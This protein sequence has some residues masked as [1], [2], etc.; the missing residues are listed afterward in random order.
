MRA[1]ERS[2]ERRS[3]K[4]GLFGMLGSVLPRIGSGARSLVLSGFHGRVALG[5]TLA[6][7]ASLALGSSSAVAS[8]LPHAFLSWFGSAGTGAG[9]FELSGE[10]GVAVDQ[11]TGDVYV[12]DTGNHRVDEFTASGVFIHAFGWGVL[13]GAAAPQTCTTTTTC[14]AGLPGPEPGQ[15]EAPTFLAVDNTP[16][17]AG[18]LYVA[19]SG[20]HANERQTVTVN[21]TGGSYTLS[22]TAP[23][24]DARTTAGSAV[25]TGALGPVGRPGDPVS[26]PGIP[27]GATFAQRL[28]E[29]SF[30]LSA[31]ATATAAHVVLGITETTK[32]SIAPKATA[33]ELHA[34][35]ASL[36]ALEL[37]TVGLGSVCVSGSAGGPYTVEFCT[38][39]AATDVPQMT[40]N[41]SGLSPSGATCTVATTVEGKDTS[42]VQKF[43]PAGNLLTAWGGTP[44]GGERDGYCPSC[45]YFSHFELP[46]G[47]GV[48]PEGT[49]LVSQT[50]FGEFLGSGGGL[51]EW[52][53]SS[54]EFVG[55]SGVREGPIGIALDPAGHLYTS[56]SAHP[57]YPVIQSSPCWM[58][59]IYAECLERPLQSRPPDGYHE[60]FTL[61]HGPATG[62]AVDPATEDVYVAHYNPTGHH[63][64]IA[65]H[66]SE[67]NEFELPFGG[68]EIKTTHEKEITEAGMIAASG[69][70]GS[71]GDVYVAD[72]GAGRVEIFAPGGVRDALI[73]TRTGT[74]LGSVSSVPAG[75]A[76][77]STCS[78]SFPEGEEVTLTVTAPEHSSFLGWSGGGCSGA[79]PCQI[80]L[81][82]ATSVT[83]TFAQDRP[84]L[85]TAVV[86]AVT[87]HT[88]TLTGTVDPEGD[89]ASCRF[90][91]GPTSAY[92]A[93]AL[94]ASHPGSGAGP[95]AVSAQLWELAASTTYHYRIVSANTGGATYGPDETFTTL[96][97]GCAVNAAL[98]PPLPLAPPLASVAIVLPK[99]PAGTPTKKA[100]TN[101]QKLAK[102]LKA[103]K[104]QK[105]KSAR[106]SCEKQARKRYAPAKK[107]VKKSTRNRKRG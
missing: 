75:I 96:A 42:R 81:T 24:H 67:G 36:P 56:T 102:T 48:K 101:A 41:A 72:K 44:S 29:N 61:D 22:Y 15:F 104:K 25:V 90:E 37:G 19:D 70:I 49:L 5:A 92:G 39:L 100:L 65:A 16:G 64:D 8:Q 99:Q 57:P 26:G 38:L 32:A 20:S 71:A 30:E 23:I 103:C 46:D 95:V 52:T 3:V 7:V 40:C 84:T 62:V 43:G 106:V 54:G 82:A 89:A 60:N 13:N 14:Q 10:A 80:A 6:L 107:K 18:D 33:E 66:H 11:S 47:V 4:T 83:A 35:L 88:A 12:A 31:P 9:Q 28:S 59:N 73:V 74:S 58:E 55:Q 68:G 87:R 34:A 94:C 21:A 91:Y 79:G 76:C 17:G 45:N 1:T 77:P 85:T 97:E 69:F 53:Q 98:C 27:S 51:T 50:S 2:A 105:K 93:Q 86:S 63:S 78:T